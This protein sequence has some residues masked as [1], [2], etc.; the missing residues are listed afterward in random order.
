MKNILEKVVRFFGYDIADTRKDLEIVRLRQEK[1]RLEAANI[2]LSKQIEDL[3]D[4]TIAEMPTVDMSDPD[5]KERSKEERQNYVG[6][7]AGL[8]KD[9]L[10]PKIKFMISNSYKALEDT[11]NDRDLDMAI[12]GMIYTFRE[13]KSWGDRMVAEQSSY[14]SEND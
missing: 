9:V 2:D 6:K 8:H 1:S 3:Q 12:K 11:S 10:E 4:N 7:V 13:I 5:K 14:R